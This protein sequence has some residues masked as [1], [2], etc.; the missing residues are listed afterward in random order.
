M[1]YKE[2]RSNHI[3]A[4]KRTLSEKRR[5]EARALVVNLTKRAALSQV[6]GQ[7]VTLVPPPIVSEI[8]NST[9]SVMEITDATGLS[10]MTLSPYERREISREERF[11]LESLEHFKA[12][13]LKG[14]V[15]FF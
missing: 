5:E 7:V 13:A 11:H 9:S 6:I 1:S 8:Y 14:K 4:P 10:V 3:Q 2:S 15:R 12:L